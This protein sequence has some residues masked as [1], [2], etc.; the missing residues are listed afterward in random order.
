[1]V[2]LKSKIPPP[3]IDKL[4]KDNYKLMDVY[5]QRLQIA[6]IHSWSNFTLFKES[7]LQLL[8]KKKIGIIS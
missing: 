5:I 8:R 7:Y 1:M 6:L 4:I 2:L 3:C